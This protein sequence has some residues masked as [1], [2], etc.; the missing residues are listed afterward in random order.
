MVVTDIHGWIA[1]QHARHKPKVDVDFGHLVAL[2]ER[3]KEC[4]DQ[5]DWFLLFNGD[6]MD[7]TGLSTV[8]PKYLAPLLEEVPFSALNVGNHELYFNEVVDFMMEEDGFIDSWSGNYLASNVDYISH[9]DTE[10]ETQVPFGSRYT[11]LQGPNSNSTLLTFGF[12]FNF[13]GNCNHTEVQ[14]VEDTLQE[15]WFLQALTTLEY[16]GIVV[17]AHMDAVDDLVYTIQE[18]IRAQVDVD[19]PLHFF[20]GH[21]H[22]R[23]YE[24][25][26]PQAASLEAGHFMDTIGF[27]S[28][29]IN[30]D[31]DFEHVFLDANVLNLTTEVLQQEAGTDFST[32]LGKQLSHKMQKAQEKLGLLKVLTTCAPQD[33]YGLAKPADDPDSLW[34]L[35][36]NEVIPTTLLSKLQSSSSNTPI[37]IQGTGALRYSLYGPEIVVDDIIAVTPFQDPVVQVGTN[38]TA[39]E[40]NDVFAGLDV[41]GTTGTWGKVGLVN[42]GVA[43]DRPSGDGG[44]DLYDLYTVEFHVNQVFKQVQD[45]QPES[46]SVPMPAYDSSSKRYRLLKEKAQF[47]TTKLWL[48]FVKKEWQCEEEES[49]QDN[50][51]LVS[52]IGTNSRKSS[53]SSFKLAA[54]VVFCFVALFAWEKSRRRR[55]VLQWRTRSQE[56]GERTSLLQKDSSESETDCR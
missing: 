24:T 49:L 46:D 21:T 1:G 15:E 32:P 20:T 39:S 10:E 6:F 5:R 47:E 18:A 38:L 53:A 9:P 12:L 35:Y 51:L 44:D 2:Y 16:D 43:G 14:T 26:D 30:G 54:L 36:L 4:E 3:L 37:F 45:A 8:P 25:L 56:A 40:L 22:R 50:H 23:H 55:A 52:L 11:L 7:G 31:G 42:F 13:N 19:V 34:W 27:A 48:K 41:D 29:P 33:Y 28:F 17:L